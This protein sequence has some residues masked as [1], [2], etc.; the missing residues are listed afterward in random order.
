ME[1]M[2]TFLIGII[3]LKKLLVTNKLGKVIQNKISLWI[4]N[5]LKMKYIYYYY[6]SQLVVHRVYIMVGFRGRIFV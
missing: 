5:C 2:D 6:I 4:V 3:S 1:I